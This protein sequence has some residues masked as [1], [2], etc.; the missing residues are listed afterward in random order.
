M[1][2]AEKEK[3]KFTNLEKVYFPQLGLTKGDV[4]SYYEKIAPYILPYLKDRPQSLNRHPNGIHKPHFFQKNFPQKT[5]PFIKKFTRT[6]ES[7]K[8]KVH[9]LIADNKDALLYIINLGCIEI[10]P[11]TSRRPKI[12][13][14]DFKYL[15]MGMT[16]TSESMWCFPQ[17]SNIS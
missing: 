9:Y 10:N 16:S 14:P 2:T 17:K 5:P 15:S 6:S 8:E 1:K 13:Y 7:K 3:N 4:I 12:N 11:W